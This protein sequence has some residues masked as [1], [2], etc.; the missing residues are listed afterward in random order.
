MDVTK[1]YEFTWFGD[2]HGPKPYT[3]ALGLVSGINFGFVLHH[4][5]ARPVGEGLGAKFGRK[6]AKTRIQLLIFISFSERRG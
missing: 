4:F 5:R 6:P 3:I 2:I 1:P